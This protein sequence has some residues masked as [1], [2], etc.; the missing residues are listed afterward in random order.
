MIRLHK[1]NLF[2]IVFKDKNE[3]SIEEVYSLGKRDPQNTY[4]NHKWI[5]NKAW[6]TRGLVEPLY[7]ESTPKIS[8][9]VKGFRLT[10]KGKCLLG[11][12]EE[13]PC[14][15]TKPLPIP[16]GKT[17]AENDLR[18]IPLRDVMNLISKL[19]QENPIREITFNLKE[20][21]I[22]IQ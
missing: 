22:S 17:K 21:V 16:K 11:R 8:S 7:A 12:C 20:G 15:A 18:G 6:D 13:N 9:N 5:G 1:D 4:K 10:L 2:L 19:S 3:V 14:E